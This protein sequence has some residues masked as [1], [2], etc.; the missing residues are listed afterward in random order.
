MAE[1]LNNSVKLHT[2]KVLLQKAYGEKALETKIFPLR[3]G[4]DHLLM[5]I[6]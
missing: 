4:L 3:R 1:F 6:M 2:S 5:H